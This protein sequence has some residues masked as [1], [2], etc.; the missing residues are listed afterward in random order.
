MKKQLYFKDENSKYAYPLSY[1]IG[2]AKEEGLEEITLIEAIPDNDNPDY[3]YCK[4]VGEAGDRS[5]CR[6]SQCKFY[7]SKSGRGV[8]VHRGNI[9]DFGEERKIK[10]EYYDTNR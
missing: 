3:I 4:L 2:E 6:K 9:C 8:C 7:K 1:F 5:E 10:I